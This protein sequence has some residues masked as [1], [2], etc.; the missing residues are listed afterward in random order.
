MQRIFRMK[1]KIDSFITF[2][3]YICMYV[4][5]TL[6]DTPCSTETKGKQTQHE[7]ESK[8]VK[9]HF[10]STLRI[11]FA[12]GMSFDLETSLWRTNETSKMP[13]CFMLLFFTFLRYHSGG[14]L[15]IYI[16]ICICWL[17]ANISVNNTTRDYSQWLRCEN[18]FRNGGRRRIG[19][20]GGL[21][22]Y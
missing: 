7:R 2:N 20:W 19:I 1:E 5:L 18:G 16:Y 4:S 22:R 12:V 17:A 13:C 14:S 9:K 11:S 21:E 6:F 8:E 15:Y 3:N 10:A